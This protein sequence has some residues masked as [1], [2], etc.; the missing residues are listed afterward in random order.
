[1]S[2]RQGE[3]L[4]EQVAELQC[5]YEERKTAQF[6][7]QNSGMKFKE[8]ETLSG[9]IPIIQNTGYGDGVVIVTNTFKPDHDRPAICIPH[10]SYGILAGYK[11]D[12]T[13]DY[14]RNYVSIIIYDSAD[15]YVGYVDIL[16][17][18]HQANADGY[19]WKTVIYT[20]S[21]TALTLPFTIDLRATD[22]GTHTLTLESWE[23]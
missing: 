22:S 5:K 19:A 4:A 7:S 21:N 17:F 3:N 20:W 10:F 8:A 9:N 14:E 15:N 23:L 6:T 11:T 16:E 13:Y 1:M 18:Y 12:I 2:L